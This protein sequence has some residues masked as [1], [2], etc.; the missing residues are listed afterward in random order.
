MKRTVLFILATVLT[1]ASVSAKREKKVEVDSLGNKI[2]TGWNFGILPSVAYDADYGFQGGVLTNIYDYG[3]GHQYPEYIHSI[4]VEAAYTTK[5]HG[6]FRVNYDSKYLIPNHR[7]TLD[8]TYLP[9][10]MCDFY[11][12][13]GYQ[14]V[15]NNNW[16][17]W[18]K[19]P[20]KMDVTNYQSRV[21][22]KYKRDLIRFAADVEGTIWKD[23]KWNAGIGVLGYLID[24]CD[25]EMLNG[26]KHKYEIDPVTGEKTDWKSLDPNV[27]GLFQ[28]YKDW[29]LINAD[30]ARG[31][32]HPYARVGLSYDTRD[33]RQ[34]P[35]RGIYADAFFTYSAAFNA[36]YGQQ[37]AAG[38]NHL[39]F[40]ATF[41]HYV[42]VYKD[43]ITFAYRL[44]TQNVI[45][46]KSPFY[47][48]T[49]LNT[50]FIQRVLYEGLGGGNS[51]RGMM[52][53][54]ILADGFAY[55]NIEF[56]FRVVNFDI[57]RQ[58]F[59]IGLNP[60]FDLGVVTQPYSLGVTEDELK[61]KILADPDVIAHNTAHPESPW[62]VEQFFSFEKS[63]IYRPHMTAGIG[64][65]IG[66]NENFV[67][68]ADW[69]MPVNE[70][71]YMG[72]D[73]A[74]YANFYV[75]MGYLF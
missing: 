71:Y 25:I 26:K 49:Y 45:A 2:K 56:R 73:N 10:A 41:R 16:H 42:P 24:D 21:Y 32:W 72:Q 27:N 17:A 70:K 59:F 31:G 40:N 19:D 44:G 74:K 9:D 8:A 39:Q 53:N 38:Y 7:L 12:F 52:A 66:M 30:E 23:I 20:A 57:K 43:R 4:Y 22:Y 61:A 65:K 3:D 68:S 18:K 67:L 29:G 35:T 33:K 50:Q 47:M 54:R 6:I 51:I 60:F 37:A 69:A 13:N 58:H 15:Y 46:G 62:G 1:V 64:L 55:A 5:H 36:A 75:K 48:N 11:G 28:K 63:D 14:G 34:G